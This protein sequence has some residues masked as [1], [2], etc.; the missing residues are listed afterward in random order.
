MN[1]GVEFSFR[2]R[3]IDGFS[4]P[5]IELLEIKARAVAE[6]FEV[7]VGAV[8]REVVENRDAPV[9]RPEVSGCVAADKAC[10]A[11]NQ[12]VFGA[13]YLNPSTP[14]DHP[15]TELSSA[16]Y[17]QKPQGLA[18][19]APITR[20]ITRDDIMELVAERLNAT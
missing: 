10:T 11:C 6:P 3:R 17:R 5:D 15:I 16:A 7:L 4:L 1:D 20:P 18:S 9:P 19:V 14:R 2:N 12:N 8:A 13:H